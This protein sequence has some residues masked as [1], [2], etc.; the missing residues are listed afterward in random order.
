MLIAF[1]NMTESALARTSFGEQVC[2]HITGVS[3]SLSS[4]AIVPKRV[5]LC[6]GL[7]HSQNSRGRL[8]MEQPTVLLRKLIARWVGHSDG[9]RQTEDR[10]QASFPSTRLMSFKYQ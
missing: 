7:E 9:Q 3:G 6:S 8:E 1:S 2:S 4:Q 5:F 10:A